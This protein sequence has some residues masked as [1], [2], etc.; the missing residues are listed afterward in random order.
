MNI[1][2]ADRS[3]SLAVAGV[4]GGIIVS[5][6]ALTIAPSGCTSVAPTTQASGHDAGGSPAALPTVRIDSPT[7]GQ[8]FELTEVD[9]DVALSVTVG[10]F[11]LVPLG[12][13][14]DDRAKGQVR[15]FVDDH[16]CDDPGDPDQ[17]EEP[18]PYN[19]ILPNDKGESTIGLDYCSGGVLAIDGKSHRLRAELWHGG[20]P[21]GV[22]HAITFRTTFRRSDAGSQ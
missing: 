15:V 17:H 11:T 1:V 20:Q 19:R 4:V 13:E 18:A 21:I 9:T 6:G 2:R 8:S 5:M 10:S 3:H 12:Q 22:T 14:G 16:D 7:E